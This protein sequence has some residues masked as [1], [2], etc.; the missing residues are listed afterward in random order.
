[1]DQS[2]TLVDQTLPLIVRVL[3]GDK[4]ECMEFTIGLMGVSH[5]LILLISPVGEEI[6]MHISRNADDII[7]MSH[8]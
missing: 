6:N 4:L 7:H 2:N 8:L 5:M 3:I 1:M